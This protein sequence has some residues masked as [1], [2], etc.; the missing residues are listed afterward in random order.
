M[1][2]KVEKPVWCIAITF[3]DEENNGFVTLGG[4]GWERVA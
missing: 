3:G 4:A 2:V 1:K